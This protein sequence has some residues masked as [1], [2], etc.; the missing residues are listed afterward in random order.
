M[1][2]N[3]ELP[4]TASVFLIKQNHVLLIRRYNTGYRDWS[5]WLPGGR[6]QEWESLSKA[7]IWEA[8]EEVWVVIK[9][10]DLSKPLIVHNANS[11]EWKWRIWFFSICKKWEWEPFNKEPEHCSEIQWFPIDNLPKDIIPRIWIILKNILE[12][13]TYLE[14]GFDDLEKKLD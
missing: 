13:E 2:C 6:L 10:E 11:K 7:A 3:I 8:F 12:W 9:E 4:I 14:I 1:K 5:R